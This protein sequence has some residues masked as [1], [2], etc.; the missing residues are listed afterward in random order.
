MYIYDQQYNNNK[1]KHQL[2]NVVYEFTCMLVECLSNNNKTLSNI[3]IGYEITTLSYRLTCKLSHN[4]STTSH[5]TNQN[6]NKIYQ[7]IQ[8]ILIRQKYTIHINCLKT[9][10]IEILMTMMGE[11][12]IVK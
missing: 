6:S 12:F 3:Y 5:I 2:V 9:A 7:E 1:P 10:T 11:Y 4:R 8:E